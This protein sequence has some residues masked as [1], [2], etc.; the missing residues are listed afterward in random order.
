VS[1]DAPTLLKQKEEASKSE[2]AGDAQHAPSTQRDAPGAQAEGGG[3]AQAG[4]GVGE[5]GGQ[6]LHR[7]QEEGGGTMARQVLEDADATPPGVFL[8]IGVS[9]RHSVGRVQKRK[10]KL[11]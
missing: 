2:W 9:A 1:D 4:G 5:E 11:T 7:E 3:G 6:G 8:W 10:Y